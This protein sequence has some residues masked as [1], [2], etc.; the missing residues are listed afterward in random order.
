[1]GRAAEEDCESQDAGE[2]RIAT[3]RIT[4][5]RTERELEATRQLF[6]AYAA[7]LPVDLG[8]QRFESELAQIPGKYAPPAGE[9][10]IAW[11]AAGHAI[12]CVGLRPLGDQQCEMKRLYVVPDARCLGL[13]KALTE[14]VIELARER[15]YA[16]LLLDTLA[17]MGRATG[18]YE[19][20]GFER[21][22]PYYSPTPPGTIFM[23]L[24]L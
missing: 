23:K 10:L 6:E 22:E 17:T 1:M 14:A 7:S 9:I 8:Y 4:P 20:M 21:I 3:F 15:G 12:G 5:A 11:D 24:A 2:T 18:I 19:R 16:E 13:G